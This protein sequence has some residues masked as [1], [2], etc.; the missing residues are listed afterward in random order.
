M[1][2]YPWFETT[3]ALL[4]DAQAAGHLPH[5]ILVDVP[6]G[7]GAETLTDTLCKSLLQLEDPRPARELAHVD[8]R[9]LAPEDAEIKVDE[10]RGLN[11]WAAN[12][13]SAAGCKVG[14]IEHAHRMNAG[15]ANAL[16]KTLEEPAQ[17]T[18]LLLQ[19]EQPERLLATVRSRCQRVPFKPA[20][21]MARAWLLERHPDA[22]G[23]LA[24]A[25]GGPLEALALA[26]GGDSPVA[27]GLKRLRTA[28]HRDAEFKTLLDGNVVNWLGRWYRLV[29]AEIGRDPKGSQARLSFA[30]ELLSVRRQIESSNSA[31]ARLLIER[32]LYKAERL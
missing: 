4:R 1:S 16:L 27:D 25:G 11:A 19:S 31:N 29:V 5:A 10:I 6:G 24:E 2:A 17:N 22:S 9:W 21:A 7:W 26:E 15:A 28:E 18:Y 23:F 8:L 20:T 30:D 3:L 13:P 14:V 32:L 12:R